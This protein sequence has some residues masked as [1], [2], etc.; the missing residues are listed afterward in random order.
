MSNGQISREQNTS[1]HAENRLNGKRIGKGPT[2]SRAVN[3]RM[4]DFITAESRALPASAQVCH[5]EE[6]S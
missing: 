6:N 2:F 3:R 4:Q 1:W 5:L